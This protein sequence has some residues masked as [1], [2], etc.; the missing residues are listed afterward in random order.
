VFEAGSSIGAHV[1]AW[2]HVQVFSPRR[3]NVDAVAAKLLHAHGWAEPDPDVLP[4]GAEL[5]AH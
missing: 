4:T 1:A 3:Y 5:I 2:G